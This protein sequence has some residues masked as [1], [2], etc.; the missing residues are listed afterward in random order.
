MF[1]TEITRSVGCCDITGVQGGRIWVIELGA[2][3]RIFREPS[4]MAAGLAIDAQDQPVVAEGADYGGRRVS[5]TDLKTG[6]YRVIRYF[7]E[8]RQLNAPN[9]ELA[10]RLMLPNRESPVSVGFGRG[11]EAGTLYIATIGV[12]KICK[13]RVGKTGSTPAP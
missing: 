7:F 10:A 2:K 4:N 12:G 3:P 9:G 5:L 1:F 13:L 8:N 11:A 6:E